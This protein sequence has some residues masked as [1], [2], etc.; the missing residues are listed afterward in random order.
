MT[1]T[2]KDDVLEKGPTGPKGTAASKAYDPTTNIKRKAGNTGDVAGEGKN[3]NVKSY[4]TK[5]GQLSAKQQAKVENSRRRVKSLSGPVKTMFSPEEKMRIT[6][7]ALAARDF[8]LRKEDDFLDVAS[9]GKQEIVEGKE[10]LKLKKR[11]ASLKKALNHKEAIMDLLAEMK[12]DDEPE[13]EEQQP[14]Q[15][16]S[17]EPSEEEQQQP[18]DQGSEEAS[19]KS[20]PASEE[21]PSEQ[22]APLEAVSPQDEA[23]PDKEE[24]INAL[25]EEGHSDAEIAYIVHGH[26]SPEVDPAKAANAQAAT[27][28]SNVKTESAS[29]MADLQHQHEQRSLDHAHEHSRRMLDLE[30]E[31]A[32]S[33]APDAE[34]DKEA[35]KQ[36]K[37]L[38]VEKEKL[39]LE[40]RREEIKMELEFKRREL[41][42]KLKQMELQFNA[43]L[44]GGN[45]E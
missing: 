5:P 29:K 21:V 13:Q 20:A 39:E 34:A 45:N 22:E 1:K 38:E 7:E 33:G 24:L 16:A 37:Q 17:E 42:L 44:T 2:D 10:P 3:Q 43:K 31:T 19:E 9:D 6:T 27:D 8:K 30:Y 26:H 32:K 40:L 36:L 23:A 28:M 12:P 25:R 15:E 14:E 11:W 4:S 41:E 18:V 35:N